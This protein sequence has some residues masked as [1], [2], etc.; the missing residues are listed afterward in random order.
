MFVPGLTLSF[1]A[2]CLP[3][4]E[5]DLCLA[6]YHVVAKRLGY[7]SGHVSSSSHLSVHYVQLTLKIMD[8]YVP[9]AQSLLREL[10]SSE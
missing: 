4:I 10:L 9:E 2:Q 5:S 3:Q 6:G 1:K 7:H 8:T